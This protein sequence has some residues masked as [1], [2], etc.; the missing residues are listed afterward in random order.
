MNTSSPAQ[1][2]KTSEKVVSKLE[3]SLDEAKKPYNVFRDSP[4]RYMGYANEIGES[5][6]YQVSF[7]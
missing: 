7:S 3:E 2:E 5:F 6:R 1:T 4:L